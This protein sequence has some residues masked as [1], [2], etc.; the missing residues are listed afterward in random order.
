MI[1]ISE[2]ANDEDGKRMCRVWEDKDIA[3][4]KIYARIYPELYTE[5]KAQYDTS[6]NHFYYLSEEAYWQ[7]QQKK[8]GFV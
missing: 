1:T 5:I 2:Y 7:L 3:E 6:Q 4:S 8:H